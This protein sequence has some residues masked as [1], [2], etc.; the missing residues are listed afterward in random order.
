[1]DLIF[2]IGVRSGLS[3]DELHRFFQRP[4]SIAFYPPDSY[5]ERIEQLYDMVMVMMVD[6]ASRK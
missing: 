4:E 1:M 2:K 5:R 3:P 6:R